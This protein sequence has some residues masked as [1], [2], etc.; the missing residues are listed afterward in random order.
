M[1]Q[2]DW[3]PYITVFAHDNGRMN[4]KW[5]LSCLLVSFNNQNQALAM[6]AGCAETGMNE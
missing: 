1:I 2:Q 3:R 6:A 4:R 5:S